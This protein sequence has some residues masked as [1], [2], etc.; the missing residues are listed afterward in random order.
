MMGGLRLIIALA[1]LASLTSVATASAQRGFLAQTESTVALHLE[2]GLEN[3]E[4]MVG[5]HGQGPS[6]FQVIWA[7]LSFA[8]FCV[9]TYL[10]Y[11]WHHEMKEEAGD[12]A[13]L[14]PQFGWKSCGCLVCCVCTGFGTCMTIC[15]PIDKEPMCGGEEKR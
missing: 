10:V 7:L 5:Q 12:V 13:H 8:L 11:K 14:S 3:V 15:W 2:H 6:N 9:F 1:A 4:R